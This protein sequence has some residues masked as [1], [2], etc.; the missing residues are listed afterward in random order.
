MPPAVVVPDDEAIRNSPDSTPLARY[1]FDEGKGI[2]A[3]SEA[4]GPRASIHGAKHVKAGNGYALKFDGN[5]D[6]VTVTESKALSIGGAN[7][8]VECWFRVEDLKATWRGLCGNYHSGVSGYMLVY[9]N[10][11]SVAFYSG[12][13]TNGPS[14]RIRSE[15]GPWHHA[16]GVIDNGVMAVYVDGMRQTSAGLADQKIKQG[17]YP[18]EIGRYNLGKAFSGQIDDVAVYDT[19]MTYAQIVKRYR[20]GRR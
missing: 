1:C 13:A 6:Y 20:K 19:P 15:N 3:R 8:T 16:V 11:Q 10:S 17:D 18:F 12:A 2:V 5:D 7:M 14:C 4:N 9:T